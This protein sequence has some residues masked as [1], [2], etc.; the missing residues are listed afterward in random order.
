MVTCGQYDAM[1]RLEYGGVKLTGCGEIVRWPANVAVSLFRIVV[2]A[3]VGRAEGRSA[4]GPTMRQR[5]SSIWS[6]TK[7][8]TRRR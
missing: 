1:H 6:A 3:Y 8:F 2:F 4:N 7:F 5:I